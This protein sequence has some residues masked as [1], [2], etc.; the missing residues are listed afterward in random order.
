MSTSPN[1]VTMFEHFLLAVT[2]TIS[3]FLL[4]DECLTDLPFSYS[5]VVY[6]P[7]ARLLRV[8]NPNLALGR[9]VFSTSLFGPLL[10]FR[11]LHLILSSEY[12]TDVDEYAL[13]QKAVAE[14]CTMQ[15]SKMMKSWVNSEVLSNLT[16]STTIRPS[17]F[18]WKILHEAGNLYF[19]Y[20]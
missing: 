4:R 17:L 13:L 6:F 20:H 15:I 7:Y 18:W 12:Y 8:Q 14:V 5:C 10:T 9:F 16:L 19:S 1:W 11:W 2:L 3:F